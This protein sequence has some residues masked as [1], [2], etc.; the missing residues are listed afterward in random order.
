V[1]APVDLP[2]G[3]VLANEVKMYR[4]QVPLTEEIQQQINKEVWLRRHS[5][6]YDP[7]FNFLGAGPDADL[8]AELAR[9]RI[10]GVTTH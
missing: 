4:R 10:V 7:R 1:D 3:G 2:A 9:N 8:A 5:S 6:A